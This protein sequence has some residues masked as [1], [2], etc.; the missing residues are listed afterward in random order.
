MTAPPGARHVGLVVEGPGDANALP[1]VLRMHRHSQGDFREVDG[2]PV[3]C[4]GRTKAARQGGLEG[5]VAVAASRPG[6]VGVLVLLDGEGDAV[7]T[8]GPDFLQRAQGT[9]GRPCSVA[10]ADR[11]FETWLRCSAET[12]GVPGF[13][14][15]GAGDAQH[16]LKES[17]KPQKYVKPTWQPKL[18]CKMDL[19]LARGR[20]H[21]LDRMLHRYDALCALV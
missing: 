21:S 18:A 17:L 5:F 13:E 15:G 19:V 16:A 14:Y 7:C 3:V 12:L 6:C 20:S 1:T 11:D 8:A 10:L 2:R 4:N 9:T